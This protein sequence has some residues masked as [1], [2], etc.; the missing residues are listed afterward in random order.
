MFKFKHRSRALTNVSYLKQFEYEQ[1]RKINITELVV[2]V[3]IFKTHRFQFIFNE[4]LFENAQKIYDGRALCNQSIYV[5]LYK[6]E[7]FNLIIQLPIE[8]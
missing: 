8:N 3:L 5:A 6:Y 7:N 2:A 1:F 4:T